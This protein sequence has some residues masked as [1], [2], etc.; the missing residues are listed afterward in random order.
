MILMVAAMADA[1]HNASHNRF[2]DEF[3]K[4]YNDIVERISKIGKQK[5][6]PKPEFV[7]NIVL[8]LKDKKDV[9]A[10]FDKCYEEMPFSIRANTLKIET[11]KLAKRLQRWDVER[12]DKIG[13]EEAFV[14]KRRLE[15]GELGNAL[16]HRLGYFYVQS[17]SSMLPSKILNAEKHSLVLD[18]CAAP[19]SKTTHIAALMQN[20]GAILANDISWQRNIALI[21]NLQRCGVVNAIVT[22]IPFQR[23]AKQLKVKFDYILADVPCSN[24][25]TIRK[26]LAIMKTW[27]KKLCLWMSKIQKS[28]LCNALAL[29]KNNGT[30]VYSTCTLNPE[31]NEAVIDFALKRFPIALE[32]IKLKFEARHG[33][34]EW[35][36]EKFSEE[37]KKA[38]RILPQDFNSEGFF[39]AKIKMEK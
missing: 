13:L 6:L 16:E 15:P 27:N 3:Q 22:S 7:E 5:I 24:E 33:V 25:G 38:V 36:G 8:L 4:I 39:I 30:L 10:F 29:L 32:K 14:I 35:K 20:T 11:E 28:I 9:L 12:Q 23:L 34:T 18:C 21:T 37:L 1:F 26:N 31:E 2:R 19:G 17:L